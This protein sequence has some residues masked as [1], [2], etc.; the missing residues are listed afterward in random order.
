[1][2][3]SEFKISLMVLGFI[4]KRTTTQKCILFRYKTIS[5]YMYK[6]EVRVYGFNC[7]RSFRLCTRSQHYKYIIEYIIGILKND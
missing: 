4:K 2:T 3:K 6:D 7:V 5:I 1:M